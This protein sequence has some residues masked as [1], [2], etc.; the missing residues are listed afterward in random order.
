[1]PCGNS[2]LLSVLSLLEGGQLLIQ[3]PQP[4]PNPNPNSPWDS[5][6]PGIAS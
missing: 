2:F 4:N 1:M 3:S 6:D 5:T